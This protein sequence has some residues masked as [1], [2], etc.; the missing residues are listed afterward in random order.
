MKTL[1]TILSIPR[2]SDLRLLTTNTLNDTIVTNVEITET[3]DIAKFVSSHTLILTTAMYYKS[4]I[5]E[6]TF[7][8]DS[9][10][11]VNCSGICIKTGRF[12]N[13][14]P[15]DIIDYAAE[16]GLPIIEIPSTKPLGGILKDLSSY[17][18]NSKE[19]EI[20]YALDV[21]KQ[22][23][24]LLLNDAPLRNVIKEL[25]KA[26]QTPILLVNPFMEPVALSDNWKQPDLKPNEIITQLIRHHS[27]NYEKNTEAILSGNNSDRIETD[28]YVIK[29]HTYYPYYLIVLSPEKIPYP[30][31]EFAIEQGLMV[32][33]FTLLKNDKLYHAEKLRKSDYFATLIERQKKNDFDEK[34]WLTYE[35]NFNLEFSKFYQVIYVKVEQKNLELPTSKKLEEKRKLAYEWL[36]AKVEPYLPKSIVFLDRA[37]NGTLI[38]IQQPVEESKLIS[39]LTTLNQEL[40]LKTGI[41]LLFSCGRAYSHLDDLSKSLTEAEIVMKDA[42]TKGTNN[43]ITIYQPKGLHLLLD[44]I[45]KDEANYFC[46]DTLKTLTHPQSEMT[47]E[48]RR[49][50]KCFLEN[51]CE[52]TKTA[53]KLFIHRNTVKYR[54]DNIEEII[55]EKIDTPENSFKLRLAIEL[56]ELD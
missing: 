44:S 4:K 49:T 51:Q 13:K 5:N 36:D 47:M 11:N 21:Q 53:N 29:S 38:L 37:K 56:S 42:I 24:T 31:S 41:S 43:N 16:K 9:L 12:I 14:I 23:S 45:D 20:S 34:L 46:L 17:L 28:V 25:G 18:N 33:S 55:G 30:A 26:L 50:L 15:Q 7:L 52:F 40:K 19:A 35:T 48:L 2:F 27:F 6:L 39:I 54:I 1:K 8:I 22:F 10:I 32:L 3:P